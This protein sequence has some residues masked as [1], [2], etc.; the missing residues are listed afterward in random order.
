[1]HALLRISATDGQE[2]WATMYARGHGTHWAA[3]L[4]FVDSHQDVWAK[5]LAD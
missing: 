3:A 1:M 5:A 2:P 4:R